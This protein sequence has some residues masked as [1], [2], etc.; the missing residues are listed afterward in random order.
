V[1]P[2]Q[3]ANRL[4]G[5]V[6]DL[7]AVI[8]P[9]RTEREWLY[10]RNRGE[11]YYLD[12]QAPIDIDLIRLRKLQSARASENTASAIARL[13]QAAELYRGDLFADDPYAEWCE[14]ERGELRERHIKVLEQLAR[15]H[16]E[17]GST[18][19]ALGRLRQASR[20]APFRDDLL[21]AQMEL[22][23]EVARPNEALAAYEEHRRLLKDDLDAEPSPDVQALHRRLLRAAPKS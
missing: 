7:R 23:A 14:A 8:E 1:D 22:L 17:L 9:H 5:V 10:V 20:S 4:H 11:L 12:V 15:L 18:D 21:L 3:G 13:E 2:R 6:H 16:I 19:K